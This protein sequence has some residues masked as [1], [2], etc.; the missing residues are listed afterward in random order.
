MTKFEFANKAVTFVATAAVSRVIKQVIDNNTSPENPLD[1]AAT[2]IG[3]TVIGVVI[4]GAVK[5]RAT[6]GFDKMVL[7]AQERQNAETPEEEVVS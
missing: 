1:E 2:W 5:D 3:S 6:A 7:A 4:T